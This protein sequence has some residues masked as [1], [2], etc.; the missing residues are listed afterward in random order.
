MA[1]SSSDQ[2]RRFLETVL[3]A[4]V[5]G[6][7][8]GA[9]GLPAGWLWGAFLSTMLGALVHRPLLVPK[10]VTTATFVFLGGMLGGAVTPETLGL[11]GKWPLSLVLLSIAMVAITWAVAVYLRYVHGWDPLSAMFASAP[12]ALSQSLALA[13]STGANVKS[14]VMVQAVRILVYTA[15]LPAVLGAAVSGTAPAPV[16]AVF[17]SASWIELLVLFA[18]CASC[19]ALAVRLR[20]PG[21]Y[22]VG[23]MLMSGVL[24]GGGWI[25]VMPPNWLANA[26]FLLLG[27]M[28]GTRFVGVDVRM[29]RS[30][31]GAAMGALAVGTVV[32]FGLAYVAAQLLAI[33]TTDM[34]LAYVPGGLEAMTILAFALKLDPAFVGAHHLARYI[35][36]TALLPVLAVYLRKR[37][38]ETDK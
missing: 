8:A 17:T 29:M 13:A 4:A 34:F 5:G 19:S 12:G 28:V 27:A 32:A 1:I 25:H 26:F 9:T 31:A 21:A 30:M 23:S 10:S 22:I 37:T 18:A 3:V 11:M 20:V 14:V 2:A 38:G 35:I 15:G 7:L 6:T 24:H 36:L 16:P 33:R